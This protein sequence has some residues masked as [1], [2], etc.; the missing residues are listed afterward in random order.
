MVIT[1]VIALPGAGQ[2]T[3]AAEQEEKMKHRLM[4]KWV[5]LPAVL[6]LLGLTAVVFAA[7]T[8]SVTS[9]PT[10]SA[11][12]WQ[13]SGTATLTN[14]SKYVC[15]TFPGTLVPDVDC[16]GNIVGEGAT[17]F[18]CSVAEAAFSGAGSSVG[19]KIAAYPN[20]G[21]GG[22]EAGAVVGTFN[23]TAV[24]LAA[25]GA[26]PAAPMPW[27]LVLGLITAVSGLALRRRRPA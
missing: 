19:W 8:I 14:P 6:L 7:A 26:V 1:W 16:T 10:L 11:G 2:T 27:L 12:N 25:L 13:W 22:V 23:P 15:V 3:A 5:V 24:S 18:T 17:P 21:C 9:G 20:T 4:T